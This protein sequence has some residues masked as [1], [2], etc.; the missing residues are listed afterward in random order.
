MSYQTAYED[1]HVAF[2]ITDIIWEDDHVERITG[3]P[4][5]VDEERL[6]ELEGTSFQE[7][8]RERQEER[9]AEYEELT[10]TI[11]FEYESP[12]ISVDSS[13]RFIEH[14]IVG[15]STV[16]QKVGE[17]P[18]EVT[19]TG[20]CRE[21]T[22]RRLDGLRNAKFGTIISNRINGGSLRVQFASVTTSPMEDSGAVALTDDDA[23]FLYT[24]TLSTVEVVV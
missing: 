6:E 14:D 3:E 22:A 23:E 9:V 4:P 8:I 19:I 16:R 2:E 12:A 24:Y 7:I 21:P 5:E 17:D 10:S 20:V 1:N 15:G 13:G 18:V 11:P